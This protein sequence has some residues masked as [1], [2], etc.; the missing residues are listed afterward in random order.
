MK[1]KVVCKSYSRTPYRHSVPCKVLEC[2]AKG[3]GRMLAAFCFCA[4]D[5]LCA[6]DIVCHAR[7]LQDNAS[8]LRD[9]QCHWHKVCHVLEL[10]STQGFRVAGVVY[11]VL[12]H[13]CGGWEGE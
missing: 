9:T 10:A 7:E 3:G 13:R 5:T 4:R 6:S 2:D 12:K 1:A 11:R 8:V